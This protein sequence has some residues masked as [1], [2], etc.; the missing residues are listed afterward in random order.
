[1]PESRREWRDEVGESSQAT[2][3]AIGTFRRAREELDLAEEEVKT[4]Q[5]CVSCAEAEVRDAEGAVSNAEASLRAARES[6]RAVERDPKASGQD[7]E[8]VR[9]AV[10]AAVEAKAQA[11]RDLGEARRN[12]ASAENAFKQAEAR[13]RNAEN[14]S[15]QAIQL[16]DRARA[17][18]HG[19]L[20][21]AQEQLRKGEGFAFRPIQTSHDDRFGE[22]EGRHDD[23]VTFLRST[24]ADLEDCL[25]QLD[26]STT[27][28][29]KAVA[30]GVGQ[31]GG[32]RDG[33]FFLNALPPLPGLWD[34]PFRPLRQ[35]LPFKH[36]LLP[37]HAWPNPRT[38]CLS[39][40]PSV[41]LSTPPLRIGTPAFR[42]GTPPLG[43]GTPPL[44]LASP[45]LRIGTPPLRLSTP[46]LGIGTP[47][48][49]LGFPSIQ[50]STPPL[51]FYTPPLKCGTATAPFMSARAFDPFSPTGLQNFAPLTHNYF[52]PCNAPSISPLAFGS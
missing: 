18:V 45:Q 44:R 17:G 16:V 52:G 6:L 19:L 47:S 20:E 51:R 25:R 48:S 42:F 13:L 40:V 10:A 36:S 26:D 14:Q 9:K 4:A 39:T 35:C 2:E 41:C 43:I 12:L 1:M 28:H 33:S 21:V 22:M 50:L 46:P 23:E 34:F 32:Y 8:Q 37:I 15:E 31:P 29:S 5:H 27:K 30:I 7:R 24:I 3:N 38:N 49:Q 11:E